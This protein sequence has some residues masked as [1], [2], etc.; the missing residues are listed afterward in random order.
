VTRTIRERK[1]HCGMDG[2]GEIGE[3]GRRGG[4]FW[5]DRKTVGKL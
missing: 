4:V 2:K 3:V 5:E 1:R